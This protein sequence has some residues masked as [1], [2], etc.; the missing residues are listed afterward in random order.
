MK[1]A[2]ERTEKRFTTSEPLIL[3]DDTA[4]EICVITLNRPGKKNAV[5]IDLLEDLCAALDQAR[6]TKRV[7][8]LK[9]SEP[10]FCS[11]LD[12]GEILD[13]EKA[14]HAL[15]LMA[16]AIQKIMSA[17]HVTIAAVQGAALAGGAA[18]MLACDF[19]VVAEDAQIGFPEV[20]RGLVPTMPLTFLRRKVGDL[21]VRELI[22]TGDPISGIEALKIG[23]VS[24]AVPASQIFDVARHLADTI[25]RNAPGALR[26]S[27]ALL[28]DLWHL[29][30]AEHLERCAKIHRR[31]RTSSEAREGFCAF[32][33]KREPKWDHHV[34]NDDTG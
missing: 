29:P 18:L 26:Q 8:I 3:V 2:Q 10:D 34:F 9:G 22:L 25:L 15:E 21:K 14:P 1:V 11:G 16:S 28:D 5:N 20:R 6:A 31:I 24:R 27:K 13:D 19:S 7:L 30:V 23:L 17:P 4:E 32:L 12:L 33:E